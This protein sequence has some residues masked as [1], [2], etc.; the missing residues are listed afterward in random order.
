MRPPTAHD[1]V[2][3]TVSPSRP[4]RTSVRFTLG[5]SMVRDTP[6]ISNT[7]PCPAMG[8]IGSPPSTESVRSVVSPVFGS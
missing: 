1:H 6:S 2:A 3:S 5:S 7:T 8:V 4:Q